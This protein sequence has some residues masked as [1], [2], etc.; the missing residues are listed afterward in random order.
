ML[1]IVLV[2]GPRGAGKTTYSK[3][4]VKENKN[5][6]LF[7][8]DLIFMQTFGK[9]SFDPYLENPF[10]YLRKILSETLWRCSL[11]SMKKDTTL[12]VDYFTG[13]NDA[14]FTL[15][16]IFKKECPESKT[17]LLLAEIEHNECVRRFYEREGKEK[18]WNPSHD[19]YLYHKLLKGIEEENSYR[20]TEFLNFFDKI[21]KISMEQHSLAFKNSS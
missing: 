16:D 15:L 21:Q 3:K 14:R 12:I 4:L 9:N 10:P 8:R 5:F 2:S 1:K 11:L 17:V 13:S 19:Y 7:S 6:Y 18:G 20:E